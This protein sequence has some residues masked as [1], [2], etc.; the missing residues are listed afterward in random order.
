MTAGIIQKWFFFVF[1]PEWLIYWRFESQRKMGH[2]KDISRN[3]LLKYYLLFYK[4][5]K[6]N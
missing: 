2:Y 5:T 6:M 4:V 3:N 1:T